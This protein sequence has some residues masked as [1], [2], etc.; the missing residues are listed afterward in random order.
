MQQIDLQVIF[1]VACC[2]APGSS[3]LDLFVHLFVPETNAKPAAQVSR[4]LGLAPISQLGFQPMNSVFPFITFL[5][6]LCEHNLGFN[7][8]ILFSE[9]TNS[10]ESVQS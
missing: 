6:K 7:R 10:S 8:L 2:A 4:I 1:A 5:R 9:L 3:V